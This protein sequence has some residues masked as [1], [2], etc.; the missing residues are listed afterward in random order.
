MAARSISAWHASAVSGVSSDGFH[1]TVSPH[2]NA[3]AVFHAQTAT[4]KLNAVITPTTPSGCQVSISRCPGRSE[5]MVLPYSCRDRPTANWQMSIISCTSP[6][7]SEVIL[8]AS[9]VTSVARSALCSTS[10]SPRRAT[11]APRDG[12]RGGAPRR[13]RLRGFGYRGVGLFGRGLGDGEQHLAGD[14]RAGLQAVAAW[15]A[16]FGA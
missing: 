10:S 6:R 3:I 9:I 15:L 5:A 2:T 13:K 14:G 16:E 11:R 7:A 4:G 1:T 12:R 8:P